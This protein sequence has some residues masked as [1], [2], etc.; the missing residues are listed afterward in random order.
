M[1]SLRNIDVNASV[2][3]VGFGFAGL[4]LGMQLKRAGFDRFTI[5]EKGPTLGGTW[6]DNRYPG[7][8][9]DIPSRLYSFSFESDEDWSRKW[10][11]QREILAY[12]QRCAK[13][14]DLLRHVC[15]GVEIAGARFDATAGLWQLE[16]TAG[17]PFAARVLVTA[18]GQLARPAVPAIE[19]L[20][21][22]RG[23]SFHSAGWPEGETLEGKRVA[24]VG[25]A[26]SAVQLVPEIARRAERLYVLQRSPN[27][28]LPKPNR[29]YTG[30]ERRIFQWAP[31]VARI[32]RWWTWGLCEARFLG[33][34]G[35]PIASAI[36]RHIAKRHL[37]QQVADPAL[38]RQL[39]PDY[40]I[41]AKR[42]LLTSDYYP[43]LQR[44]N[45]RLVTDPIGRAEQGGLVTAAGERI[46]LD[47]IV[48]A[49][50]FKSTEFLAPMRI[51]GPTGVTLDEAWRDGP[52]AYLGL[53]VAG[54]PN[55]FVTYGPNT[56]LG[57]NSILFML[58]CQTRYI[59][60]CLGAMVAQDL[61][62]IDVLP[63]V[64]A[65]YNVEIQAALAQTAWAQV[66]KSWYKN[67]R[68]R[69]VNN[70][71]YTTARY[72]LRTRRVDL[73]LYRCVPRPA[74][75][76]AVRATGGPDK[77]SGGKTSPKPSRMA[78]ASRT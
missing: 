48:F 18:V 62:S 57:H 2:A 50:G 55:L 20:D 54:F 35:N 39:T 5:F 75:E 49:T 22:F 28:V 23:R 47:T 44:P 13:K 31:S 25:N 14:Y 59:V 68:G 37:E 78:S 72:F 10:A 40:P 52:E 46:D 4:C 76:V 77:G 66:E 8:A 15:F 9:C 17:E 19:G 1:R 56:N 51:E 74:G 53:S 26:A 70:W 65:A 16:T 34:K 27:W 21:L 38:R 29:E 45:V 41:G 32:E 43:A 67:E 42:I 71:P 7:A 36:A 63:E 33:I 11:P 73:G 12:M 24:V 69:I 60:D 30:M 64:Q 58:E 61:A 6:R 3:V